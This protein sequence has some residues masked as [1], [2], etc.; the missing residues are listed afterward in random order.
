MQVHARA[1]AQEHAHAEL[2]DHAWPPVA[3]LW[4]RPLQRRH[5]LHEG[6]WLGDGGWGGQLGMR[7]HAIGGQRGGGVL[8]FPVHAGQGK[9]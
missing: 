4:A 8:G 3:H 6:A 7:T 2:H 9:V 5:A 1:R